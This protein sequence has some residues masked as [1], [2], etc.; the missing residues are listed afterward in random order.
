MLSTMSCFDRPCNI[1]RVDGTKDPLSSSLPHI[2]S[3]QLTVQS[4]SR[5]SLDGTRVR[6]ARVPPP[7][8]WE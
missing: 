5:A 1:E 3:D 8:R 7:R 4:V 6:P 2:A